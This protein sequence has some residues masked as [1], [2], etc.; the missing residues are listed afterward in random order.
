MTRYTVFQSSSGVMRHYVPPQCQNNQDAPAARANSAGWRRSVPCEV[1]LCP[2]R[3]LCFAAEPRCKVTLATQLRY[4][5][6]KHARSLSGVV[7]NGPV[8]GP[9]CKRG[10][11]P[12]SDEHA[13]MHAQ[14][15]GP[16]WP[17]H[18]ACSGTHVYGQ[19]NDTQSSAPSVQLLKHI[20][21]LHTDCYM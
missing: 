19:R 2:H 15:D 8:L 14:R 7:G 10:S 20:E 13:W 11:T 16:Q 18:G 12:T 6:Y 3:I 5:R 4:N 9:S 17:A 21:S 1:M